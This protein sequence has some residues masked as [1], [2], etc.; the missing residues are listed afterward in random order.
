MEKIEDNRC[1]IT[2]T[3]NSQDNDSCIHNKVMAIALKYGN[4]LKICKLAFV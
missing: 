2:R 4:T 1:V 3:Q